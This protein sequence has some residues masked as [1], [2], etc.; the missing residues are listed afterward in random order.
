MSGCKTRKVL[1]I[2]LDGCHIECIRTDDKYNPYRV[3]KILGVHRRQIAKY[4][5]FVS[6]LCFLK[7]FYIAGCDTMT[8]SDVIAWAKETGSIF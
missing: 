2:Q 8:T 3:Y 7:D 1:K 4:G 5:E 6:V